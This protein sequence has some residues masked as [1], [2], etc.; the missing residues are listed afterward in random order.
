MLKVEG[1]SVFL[2]IYSQRK[3][4]LS[5]L[6]ILS[7]RERSVQSTD[8]YD[9]LIMFQVSVKL[10]ETPFSFLG[11]SRSC[12]SGTETLLKLDNFSIKFNCT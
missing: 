8:N 9:S 5:I 11:W 3:R 4:I 10:P 1:S 7:L 2:E 6:F 12:F